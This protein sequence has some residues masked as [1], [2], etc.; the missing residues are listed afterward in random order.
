MRPY[1]K[2]RQSRNALRGVCINPPTVGAALPAICAMPRLLDVLMTGV[3]AAF[4]GPHAP[5][6][7]PGAPFLA[8]LLL[9]LAGLVLFPRENPRG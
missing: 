3:F 2:P 1:L 7:L 4:T 5:V 6:F 9:A 8:S